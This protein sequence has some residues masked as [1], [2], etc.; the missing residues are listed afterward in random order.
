MSEQRDVELTAAEERCLDVICRLWKYRDANMSVRIYS[1][2]GSIKT[3]AGGLSYIDLRNWYIKDFARAPLA[4]F[5]H[6]RTYEFRFGV[7]QKSS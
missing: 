4:E 5:V 6:D 2:S 1:R 3:R 7:L